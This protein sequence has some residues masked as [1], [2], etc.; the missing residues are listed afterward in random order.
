MHNKKVKQI[1]I[2]IFPECINRF[3]DNDEDEE[4]YGIFGSIKDKDTYQIKSIGNLSRGHENQQYLF[5]GKVSL[6]HDILNFCLPYFDFDLCFSLEKRDLFSKNPIIKKVDTSLGNLQIVTSIINYD[7]LYLRIDSSD[8]PLGLLNKKKVVIIGLG[9]GGSIIATSLAKSGI[10]DFIFIDSDV[11]YEHNIIRHICGIND[12]GRFKTFVVR[13]YI[14]ERIPDVKIVTEE[15]D[16][17]VSNSSIEHF[18]ENLLSD[19]DLI[20]SATGE[21][22]I[23]LSVNRFA[24]KRNIPVVYAG[25]FEKLVG[26]IMIRVN[27]K[28]NDVCYRCIYHNNIYT[29][30]KSQ[31]SDKTIIYDYD[32][33]DILSQPGL[34]ID[35]DIFALLV[36]KFILNT[37]SKEFPNSD[38]YIFP[39]NI[40]YWYNKEKNDIDAPSFALIEETAVLNKKQGCNI[41]S[42]VEKS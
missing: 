24:Y 18:Y 35:I 3:K 26:G 8:Y 11:I 1:F 39:Y 12:I 27:P 22:N 16:F 30:N 21:H 42:D 28:E 34:G 31:P 38:N 10:K 19:V 2:V 29:I 9:S 23:S 4:E 13:D 15:Q 32:I 5:I 37:L 33:N 40:Y 36:V 7:K 6:N 41:C 20:I 25:L 17:D 14:S